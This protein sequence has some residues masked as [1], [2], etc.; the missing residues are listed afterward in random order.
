VVAHWPPHTL[1]AG[2]Q[3][4]GK[5]FA[6][7]VPRTELYRQSRASR[8]L[9][10]TGDALGAIGMR[11][12]RIMRIQIRLEKALEERPLLLACTSALITAFLA[13]LA[14]VEVAP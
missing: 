3:E 14:M 13:I 8:S 7:S 2:R 9:P 1:P 12:A 4:A 6:S 5:Q 11:P 10:Q